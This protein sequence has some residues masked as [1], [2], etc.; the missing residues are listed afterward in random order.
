MQ[1]DNIHRKEQSNKKAVSSVNRFTSETAF[2]FFVND[3]YQASRIGVLGLSVIISSF[4]KTIT[5]N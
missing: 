1:F 4:S 5:S 3:R 2:V